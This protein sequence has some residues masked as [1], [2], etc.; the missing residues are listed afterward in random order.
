MACGR[1][2]PDITSNS[3]ALSKVAE[4][5]GDF[6]IIGHNL[7]RSFFN[8]SETI[9]YRLAFNQFELPLTVLISPL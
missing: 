2:Y 7:L 4:S 8:K 1:E 5:E 9:L 3:R 6:S